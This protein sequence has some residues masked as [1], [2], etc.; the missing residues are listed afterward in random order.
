[1]SEYFEIDEVG[2]ADEAEPSGSWEGPSREEWEAAQAQLGEMQALVESVHE[3][4]LAQE[5]ETWQE[6]FS[7]ALDPFTD[8]F[9]G[10][11]AGYLQAR[12]RALVEHMHE[13]LSGPVSAYSETAA[14]AE[15][16]QILD[17]V[18][19]IESVDREQALRRA[20]EAFAQ[21]DPDKYAPDE[22]QALAPEA[23]RIAAEHLVLEQ[24]KAG[25]DETQ[26]ARLL[27]A[28]R[29]SGAKPARGRPAAAF[30]GDE[31]ALAR[32]MFGGRRA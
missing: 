11:L 25:L 32:A 17:G 12:D 1:M 3:A 9:Q 14:R 10:N 19:G 22:L 16:N 24:Q 2:L 21:L 26:L 23:L 31:V 8:E 27:T 18:E 13:T 28:G 20:D 5:H 30:D 6:E 7:E 29:T 15:A 4:E